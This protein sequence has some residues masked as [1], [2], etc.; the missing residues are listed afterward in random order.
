MGKLYNLVKYRNDLKNALYDLDLDTDI[1][2]KIEYLKQLNDTNPLYTDQISEFISRY[3][4][5][6]THSKDIKKFLS[7][8]AEQLSKDII[9]LSRDLFDNDEYR[10]KFSED[11]VTQVIECTRDIESHILSKITAYSDWHYPALQ[12]SPRSKTWIDPMVAADPLYLT[13]ISI[14]KLKNITST[15]PEI[16]Q[17]RLRLYEIQDRDFSMLPQNQFSFVLCWDNFNYLSV[18]KIEKYIREVFNLLRPGGTF[19]FSYTNCDLLGPT[20]RAE[21][22]A[23]SFC[24]FG[25][26]NQ[27][28]DNIGYEI[29]ETNDL[30]TE[31]AFNTHVSWVEIRKP[32]KLSTVKAIQAL[33][34]IIE[35]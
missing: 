30:E 13:D 16:Y 3:E 1:Y 11:N 8:S 34:E 18:E 10:S 23:S 9:N 21:A 15:Y 6:S 17:R 26:L 19:I 35:K 25:Y 7:L 29:V 28:F 5:V 24:S 33:A 4:V 12:I 32:G 14:S 20:I 2:G 27:I 22:R 31:D